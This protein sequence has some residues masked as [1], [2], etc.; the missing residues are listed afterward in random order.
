MLKRG[1]L[2]VSSALVN[3]LTPGS[4][5]FCHDVD[6]IKIISLGN[7]LRFPRPPPQLN[8]CFPVCC[9]TWVSE[10]KPLAPIHLTPAFTQIPLLFTRFNNYQ[11]QLNDLMEMMLWLQICD[12]VWLRCTGKMNQQMFWY[13]SRIVILHI[14]EFIFHMSTE[15]FVRINSSFLE[16]FKNT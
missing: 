7:F 11:L 3:L 10:L 12:T 5:F 8:C 4:A 1:L 13:S 6:G 15:S 16:Y 14:N 2:G 9:R